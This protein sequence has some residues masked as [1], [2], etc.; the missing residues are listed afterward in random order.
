MIDPKKPDFSNTPVYLKR[1]SFG[2]TPIRPNATPYVTIITPYYNTGP[3]FDETARSVLRQ[4]F[5]Q[6]E[7]LIVNDGSNDTD[8]ISTLDYYRN[9]DPRVKVIDH[10]CNRG[11]SA[12]RNTGFKASAC[13]YVVQLDSD[14]MLEPTATEKWLWFLE[15]YPEFS[16]CK[17]YSVGF[18]AQEY[19]WEKGF[20][21]GKEFLLD[22]LVDPTSMIR[23]EVHSTVEGYDESLLQGLEDWDFWLHCASLGYWGGNIPEYLDWYR[24]RQS[25]NDRWSN[26]DNGKKQRVFRKKLRE[27]YSKLW[28]GFFPN[29][30]SNNNEI[31]P[32]SDDL[33]CENLLKKDKQR[34]LMILPWL[35]IGGADKFN[36]DLLQQ[37]TNR[38]YE[39]TI[40]TTLHGDHSWL[41]YFNSYTPDIFILNH[42]LRLTDYPR[43]LRYLIHSRQ[44][45]LVMISHS[46]LGYLLLPYL[47]AYFPTVPFVDFCHVEEMYWKNGGYPRMSVE[48]QELFDSNI[49]SSEYLK[50]WMINRGANRDKISVCYTN[51]DVEQWQ[52]SEE[53]RSK[54]RN[55]LAVDERTPIILYSARICS[56]KQPRVFADSL[57]KLRGKTQNFM[58][59]VAG[60]GPDLKW[61]QSYVIKKKLNNRVIFTGAVSNQ[62]VLELMVASDIFFLP[63]KWEGISL[64]IYEAMACGLPIVGA[65]V[66][67]QKELLTPECG[68]LVSPSDEETEARE[69]SELLYR[70]IVDPNYRKKLG[71]AG[72]ERVVNYFR[73]DQMGERMVG[74]LE[75]AIKFNRTHPSQELS[76]NL[77]RVLAS[78]AVDYANLSQ[79][80]THLSF[81]NESLNL[82]LKI[83]LVVKKLSEPFFLWGVDR[84]WTWLFPL[85]E[86][87]KRI[88]LPKI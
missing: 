77:A 34:I 22:N 67:G 62:R 32:I 61:L 7:W 60:D 81:S 65:H 31:E 35:T 20:H 6:W 40:A 86:R 64:S 44:V 11:L 37:L 9:L 25:H 17:G 85:S 15:S 73:L 82:R 74:V 43:F 80:A 68:I 26:W 45:D 1:P 33:P 23:K 49:V 56:Q 14:D 24:R 50:T 13:K 51:I 42:F 52:P 79:K 72:R 28:D 59:I 47:R 29:I 4:S 63:S 78:Q 3:I 38:N 46:E 69:Y 83:F 41:P 48:Y 8:S 30:Q 39:I 87:V 76:K 27:R 71:K 53:L 84:G 54:L 36:L 88:L 16:F 10:E 75:N 58:A 2:Y 19:L 5:Q 57:I 12:A 55:E 21:N 66:G 18:G 70:L